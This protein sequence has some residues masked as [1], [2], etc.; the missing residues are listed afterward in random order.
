MIVRILGKSSYNNCMASNSEPSV[1]VSTSVSVFH[2]K[3]VYFTEFTPF[4][5][6]SH[7]FHET[8]IGDTNMIFAISWK[9]QNTHRFIISICI[10]DFTLHF[11]IK[12]L[13]Y[14]ILHMIKSFVIILITILL[15]SQDGTAFQYKLFCYNKSITSHNI[16]LSRKKMWFI[17]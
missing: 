17:K 7:A 12:I 15:G 1:L 5:R 13:S 8:Q 16:I 6:K 3:H 10:T 4:P 2:G 14:I 9:Y 11:K